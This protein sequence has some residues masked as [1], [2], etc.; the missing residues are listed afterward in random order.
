MRL[1]PPFVATPEYAQV[2]D[3]I[4][5]WLVT[6][7]PLRPPDELCERT[8]CLLSSGQ[9]EQLSID[10]N[11]EISSADSANEN[12]RHFLGAAS[13][14]VRQTLVWHNHMLMAGACAVLLN[15]HPSEVIYCMAAAA[16]PDRLETIGRIRIFAHRTITHELLIWLIPILALVYF[17]RF[18]PGSSVSM[19][20]GHYLASIHFRYWTFFLPG[21]FHLAGDI[22]TPGGIRIAGLKV[23]LGLFRTGQPTEY[24]VAAILVILAGVHMFSG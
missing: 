13:H 3:M 5:L 19:H 16:L 4:R 17:P 9:Q 20:F 2:R 12:T 23:S 21:V 18:F 6:C 10:S 15:L 11:E 22:L 1:W 24:F 7:T 8:V 14:E